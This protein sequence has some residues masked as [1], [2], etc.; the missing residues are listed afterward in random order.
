[1]VLLAASTALMGFIGGNDAAGQAPRSLPDSAESARAEQALDAFPGADVA[2]AIVVASRS[3]GAEL[4]A[5]DLAA[6]DAAVT[7]MLAVEQQ[8]PSAPDRPALVPAPDRKA[9]IGQV[10]VDA[11]LR[12]IVEHGAAAQV[13]FDYSE[14]PSALPAQ[15]QP[16][17]EA[18]AK[19]MEGLGE[20]W[21]SLFTAAACSVPRT[22]AG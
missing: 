17:V 12:Y 22:P 19:V 4:S 11:T 1:M 5:P 15:H 7:R 13:V 9:A 2:S 16:M 10:P 3:D 20:P 21:L 18:L 8:P 14:P 6:A